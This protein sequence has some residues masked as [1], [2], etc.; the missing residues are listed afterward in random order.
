MKAYVVSPH[1][2]YLDE[3]ILMKGHKMCFYKEI[4]IIIPVAPPYLEHLCDGWMI[5]MRFHILLNGI[6]VISG[7]WADNDE[8]LCNETPFTVDKIS[9]GVGI[10]P[11]TAT[12]VGQRLTTWASRAPQH[13]CGDSDMRHLGDSDMS[14]YVL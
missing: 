5:D 9:P 7:Q 2:N 13:W 8:K 10:K 1:Q 12:S 11:G 3:M 14:H 4:W 6:S